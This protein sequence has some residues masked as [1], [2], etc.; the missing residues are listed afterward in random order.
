[1]LVLEVLILEFHAVDALSA[2]SIASC[3]VSSLDHELLDDAVEDRALVPER[4]AGFTFAFLACAES[5]EVF[6]G[7]GNYIVVE[8]EGNSAF[9][10]LADGD[11]EEDSATFLLFGHCVWAVV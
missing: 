8:F 5:A 4:L 1:M 11:V 10:L 9:E 2:C 7:L 6:C 3:E